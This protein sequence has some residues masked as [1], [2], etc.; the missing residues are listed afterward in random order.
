MSRARV[1]ILVTAVALVA[2]AAGFLLPKAW[3]PT[4]STTST[5][6]PTPIASQLDLKLL[7]EKAVSQYKASAAPGGASYVDP[8]SGLSGKHYAGLYQ[9]KDPGRAEDV[10]AALQKEVEAAIESRGG[11]I[12]NRGGGVTSLDDTTG[13]T[14]FERGY[15]LDGRAGTVHAWCARRGEYVSV[16][17]VF[18]EMTDAVAPSAP[19][20]AKGGGRLP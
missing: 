10:T 11:A 14:Y 16:V 3:S 9:L 18:Y 6:P 8:A 7:L 5:I 19:Q 17:L 13:M 12:W 15:R 1:W 2:F 4:T 20:A